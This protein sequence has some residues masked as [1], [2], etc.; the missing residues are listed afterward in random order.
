MKDTSPDKKKEL[1][2]LVI[3]LERSVNENLYP[4]EK[5]LDIYKK[6]NFSFNQLFQVEDA[7]KNLDVLSLMQFYIKQ[8]CLHK[9]LIS[10]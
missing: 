4:Y 10:N 1:N 7:V 9:N 8:C 6:Y 5:I 2:D 3:F